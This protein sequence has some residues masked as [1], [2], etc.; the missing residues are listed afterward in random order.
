VEN[1]VLIVKR[2]MEQNSQYK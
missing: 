2:F 1:Y